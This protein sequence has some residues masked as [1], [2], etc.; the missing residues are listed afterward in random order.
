[1]GDG[2]LL[3]GVRRLIQAL[4]L[5]TFASAAPVEVSATSGPVKLTFSV[6]KTELKKHQAPWIKF[7]VENVGDA[8]ISFADDL[9]REDGDAANAYASAWRSIGTSAEVIWPN[10]ESAGP[11]PSPL[12]VVPVTC[13]AGTTPVESR[14][15]SN[16]IIVRLKPGEKVS[17]PGWCFEPYCKKP[18]ARA[19]RPL[20]GYIEGSDL[21]FGEPGRYGLRALFRNRVMVRGEGL[22]LDFATPVLPL[23]VRP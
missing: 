22:M 9:Y 4:L 6:H 13:P 14:I 20:R 23:T 15:A 5:A 8:D 11:L 21:V 7:T 10:G 18:G 3:R 19:C 12:D 16:P 2:E 1:V 17:S